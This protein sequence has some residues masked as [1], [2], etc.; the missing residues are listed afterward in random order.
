M[1]S[2]HS[3]TAGRA[4]PPC[5]G[6][7]ETPVTLGW[8]SSIGHEAAE[9]TAG[10]LSSESAPRRDRCRPWAGFQQPEQPAH[11]PPGTSSLTPRACRGTTA[12]PKSWGH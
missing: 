2:L 11:G 8:N 7:T 9:Q 10:D 6:P 12:S 3:P 1:S 5:S 4:F